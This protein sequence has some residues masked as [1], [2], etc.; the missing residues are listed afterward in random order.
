M[1]PDDLERVQSVILVAVKSDEEPAITSPDAVLDE[2]LKN[3]VI[4]KIN[5]KLPVLTDEYA[6]VDYYTDKGIK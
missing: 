6:P 1:D 2:Y 4:S 5:L 3:E